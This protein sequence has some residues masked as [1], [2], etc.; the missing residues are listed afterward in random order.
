MTQILKDT[1]CA[2]VLVE[3]EVNSE[4]F[5]CF[6]EQNNF[7]LIQNDGLLFSN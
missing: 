2:F 1:C 7:S 5:S 6:G 4:G 3:L